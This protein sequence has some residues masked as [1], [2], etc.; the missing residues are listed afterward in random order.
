[1]RQHV[2]KWGR[3]RAKRCQNQEMIVEAD[4]NSCQYSRDT[5]LHKLQIGVC[6]RLIKAYL[7]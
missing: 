1:M 6:I 7:S 4:V 5:A 2:G 3:N